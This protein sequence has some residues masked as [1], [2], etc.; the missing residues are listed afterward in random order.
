MPRTD[1]NTVKTECG[2]AH[3]GCHLA[4][5]SVSAFFQSQLNPTSGIIFSISDTWNSRA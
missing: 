5:L 2:M 4:D 3:G 1:A